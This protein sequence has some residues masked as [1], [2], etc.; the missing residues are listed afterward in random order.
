MKV[1]WLSFTA[2]LR[3]VRRSGKKLYSRV[4]TYGLALGASQRAFMKSAEMAGGAGL[5]AITL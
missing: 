1:A 2:H 3:T 4:R 5:A